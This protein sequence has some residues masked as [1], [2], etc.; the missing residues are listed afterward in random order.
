M[1]FWFGVI[2]NEESCLSRVF[3][4][5]VLFVIRDVICLIGYC[6]AR[7]HLIFP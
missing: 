4:L 6:W 7:I 5:I 2:L 3:K 1:D